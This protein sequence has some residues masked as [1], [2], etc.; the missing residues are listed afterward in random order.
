MLS[1]ITL[2]WLIDRK[3]SFDEP[4]LALYGLR[5]CAKLLMLGDL[6]IVRFL[7]RG[8]TGAVLKSICL[9]E[10][11]PFVLT[12]RDGAVRMVPSLPLLLLTLCAEASDPLRGVTGVGLDVASSSISLSDTL[13]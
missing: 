9:E 10:T 7:L 8:V 5:L 13:S 11:V 1:L 3:L 4:V 2:P 6:E 12:L